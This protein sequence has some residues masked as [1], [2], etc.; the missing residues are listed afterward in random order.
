[1]SMHTFSRKHGDHWLDGQI[2]YVDTKPVALASSFD[3]TDDPADVAAQCHA[4]DVVRALT[5]RAGTLLRHSTQEDRA[6]HDRQLILDAAL[7]VARYADG[8]SAALCALTEQ[9]A[10]REAQVA[11][12]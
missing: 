4:W 5:G 2:E 12:L 3:L 10:A 11:G 1:M 9:R 8:I 6:K 7:D